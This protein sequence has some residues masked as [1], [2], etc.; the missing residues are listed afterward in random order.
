MA[1]S[2]SSFSSH[3]PQ[4]LD[5]VALVCIGILLVIILALVLSGDQQAPQVREFSWQDRQ[6]GARDAAFVLRFSR[7]MDQA[8]V[9]NSL[10]IQPSLPGRISWAGRRM[11]YTLDRPAPYGQRF[12]LRVENARDR[13]LAGDTHHQM[14][15]FTAQF[16][17][18][19]RQ[20]AYIGAD[21]DEVG[22]L[23]LYNLSSN[24]KQILT[25]PN[26]TVFNFEFYPLGDRI[27]FS[28][29]EAGR[30]NPMV[31]QQLYSVTTGVQIN[32]P[33]DEWGGDQDQATASPAQQVT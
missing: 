11:V 19:D 25:P 6:V 23:V 14:P 12:S 8:S 29:A 17:T 10:K 1:V 9:V 31:E 26:L 13:F 21:G 2:P 28:A 3:F 18:R 5:R 22:R 32:A 20:F 33:S 27:L 15:P 7:P 30:P 16:Q 4:K 24:K